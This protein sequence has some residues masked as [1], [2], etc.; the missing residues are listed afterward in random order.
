MLNKL[1]L[2]NKNATLYCCFY[3]LLSNKLNVNT[4][5]HL[6]ASNV[7]LIQKALGRYILNNEFKQNI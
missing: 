7:E 2:L 3:R 4:S 1:N 5:L 6:Q